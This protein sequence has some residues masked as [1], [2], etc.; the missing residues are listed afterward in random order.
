[1]YQSVY[2][3][4]NFWSE[5]ATELQHT[6]QNVIKFNHAVVLWYFSVLWCTWLVWIY[7]IQSGYFSI[8]ITKPLTE[9]LPLMQTS[10]GLFFR[11]FCNSVEGNSLLLTVIFNGDSYFFSIKNILIQVFPKSYLKFI[12]LSFLTKTFISRTSKQSVAVHMPPI[13]VSVENVYVI[14]YQLFIVRFQQN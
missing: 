12:F 10:S 5:Q 4:V 7:K 8:N 14:V 9:Y 1:M 2:H 6:A 11:I 3:F 13:I